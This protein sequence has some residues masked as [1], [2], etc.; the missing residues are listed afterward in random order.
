V[1]GVAQVTGSLALLRSDEGHQRVAVARTTQTL[2]SFVL[3]GMYNS[4]KI[5]K[6]LADT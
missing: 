6:E 2:S 5:V 4:T 1:N 3:S